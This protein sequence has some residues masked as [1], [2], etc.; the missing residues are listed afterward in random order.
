MT[1][2][3]YWPEGSQWQG[4]AKKSDLVGFAGHIYQVIYEPSV[5]KIVAIDRN[6]IEPHA[7]LMLEGE[8]P[9]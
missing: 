1:F 2:P 3:R 8:V 6:K 9:V 5:V 7:I 4:N